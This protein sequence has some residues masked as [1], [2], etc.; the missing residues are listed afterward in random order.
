MVSFWRATHSLL[1]LWG[2]GCTKNIDRDPPVWPSTQAGWW[3]Y[4]SASSYV[5]AY[6][7]HIRCARGR[8]CGR[9]FCGVGAVDT[10]TLPRTMSLALSF[11]LGCRVSNLCSQ[12]QPN[13]LLLAMLLSSLSW[14]SAGSVDSASFSSAG[15]SVFSLVRALVLDDLNCLNTHVVERFLVLDIVDSGD[16]VCTSVSI[17]HVRRDL[18]LKAVVQHSLNLVDLVGEEFT[19]LVSFNVLCLPATEAMVRETSVAPDSALNASSATSSKP[20]SSM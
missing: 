2:H 4:Q 1:P 7:L 14:T 16:V 9:W 11:D 20:S 8:V 15:S 18:E 17:A 6:G 10:R 3:R 12:Q 13:A 19:R 5:R